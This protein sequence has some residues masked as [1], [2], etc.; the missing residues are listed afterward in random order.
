MIEGHFIDQVPRIRARRWI[1]RR[2]YRA[3][4]IFVI[5]PASPTTVVSSGDLGGFGG[6]A[7]DDLSRIDGVFGVN[8]GLRTTALLTFDTAEG[9]VQMEA[10]DVVVVADVAGAS[11]LGRD[12]LNRWL[13][14]YDPR[15][16]ILSFDPYVDDDEENDG[17]DDAR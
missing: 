15:G 14:V 1:V 10:L 12:V 6:S 13:M 3:P 5:D 16:G 8:S 17:D 9:G 2:N 11:R 4:D 7:L